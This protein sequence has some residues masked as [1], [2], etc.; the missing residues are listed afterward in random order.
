[1]ATITLE[2][3]SQNTAAVQILT[4]LISMGVFREQESD[5]ENDLKR[6][7]SGDELMRRMTSRIHE[8]F[9]NER[10]IST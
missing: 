3:D 5:F 2:Y 9:E 4:G 6:A 10:T 7:I 1:M 8:M